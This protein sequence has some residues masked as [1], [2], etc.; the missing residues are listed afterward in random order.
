MVKVAYNPWVT[1]GK[2][3]ILPPYVDDQSGWENVALPDLSVAD[4]VQK[5][6]LGTK[7]VNG[8]Q[9][10]RYAKAGGTLRTDEAAGFAQI[11]AVFYCSVQAAADQ[12]ASE[13]AVTVAV[14]DGHASNGAIAADELAGGYILLFDASSTGGAPQVLQIV[15]NTAV[16]VSVGGTMTIKVDGKIKVALTTSDHAEIMAS[17]YS[18]VKNGVYSENYQDMKVGVPVVIATSGQFLWLQTWGPCF[19]SPQDGDVGANTGGSAA[20]NNHEVIFRHDGT[21]DQIVYNDV[22][23][24]AKAQ[25]AGV[26]MARGSGGAQGAPFFWLMI[27]P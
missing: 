21:I 16:L 1:N 26:V 23:I 6:P 8:D 25:R 11:Q 13:L 18:Y 4:D 5:Y 15:S 19:L 3:L 9:V 17:P 20:S 12:Y 10:Y 24:S 27:A 14:T 2:A 22:T 7:Y